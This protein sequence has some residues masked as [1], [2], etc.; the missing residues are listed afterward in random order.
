MPYNENHQLQLRWDVFNV[1]NTQHFGT[2]DIS[3]TGWGIGVDPA[4]NASQAPLVPNSNFA[5]FIS[6]IQGSPRVMQVGLRYSF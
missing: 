6:P 1:T 2:L 5:N 3:R 4:G